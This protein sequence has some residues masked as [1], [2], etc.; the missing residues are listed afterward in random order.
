VCCVFSAQTRALSSMYA[1]HQATHQHPSVH[2]QYVFTLQSWVP[3]VILARWAKSTS[4]LSSPSLL[5][6]PHSSLPLLSPSLLACFGTRYARVC[7]SV[8][9]WDRLSVCP[10]LIMVQ[11]K[12]K[13]SCQVLELHIKFGH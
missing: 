12:F 6:S 11:L 1:D 9:L 5:L 13:C 10:A 7:G 8:C 3:S 4:S 2:G